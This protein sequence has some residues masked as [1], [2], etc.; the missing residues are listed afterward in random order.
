[1]NTALF[2]KKTSD[3]K[4]DFAD[5]YMLLPYV[6]CCIQRFSERVFQPRRSIAL[7]TKGFCYMLYAI[8]NTRT[9]VVLFVL[10]IVFNVYLVP[11]RNN[12]S[13]LLTT[14]ERGVS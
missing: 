3:P 7:T 8:S 11:P 12:D 9:A 10:A 6:D 1:M 2:R 13:V 5:G 14:T 4:A